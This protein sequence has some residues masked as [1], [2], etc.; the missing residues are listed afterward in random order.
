MYGKTAWLPTAEDVIITKVRWYTRAR[1]GKDWDDI[2]DVI[3]VQDSRLNRDYIHR[4]CE[5]H[6]SRESLKRL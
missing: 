6:G 2:R 4:W 3:S 5:I 1:R